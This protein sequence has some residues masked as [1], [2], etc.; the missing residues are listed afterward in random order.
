MA[1]CF[2]LLES[3]KKSWRGEL[4]I[5]I[6]MPTGLRASNLHWAFL[7]HALAKD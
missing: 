3:D 6:P 2:H 5:R 4:G 7:F 1:F